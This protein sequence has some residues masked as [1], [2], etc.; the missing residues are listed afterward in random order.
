MQGIYKTGSCGCYLDNHIIISTVGAYCIIHKKVTWVGV[1]SMLCWPPQW[2]F[3]KRKVPKKPNCQTSI[4]SDSSRLASPLLFE[5]RADKTNMF[6][7]QVG[8]CER[9][10]RMREAIQSTLT[11]TGLFVPPNPLPTRELTCNSALAPFGQP[12]LPAGWLKPEISKWF[13]KMKPQ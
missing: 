11:L 13:W 12:G 4:T 2:V 8:P 10:S 5:W 6:Q 7:A 1:G 3:S 9:G